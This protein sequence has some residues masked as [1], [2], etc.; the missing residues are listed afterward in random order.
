MRKHRTI[1]HVVYVPKARAYVSNDGYK[2]WNKPVLWDLR[3]RDAE[4][5]MFVARIDGGFSEVDGMLF[6]GNYPARLEL[7]GKPVSLEE[8]AAYAESKRRFGR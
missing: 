5:G 2:T 7:D 1:P 3:E 6:C 4:Y 8:L